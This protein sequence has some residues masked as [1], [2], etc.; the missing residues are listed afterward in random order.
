[1]NKLNPSREGWETGPLYVIINQDHRFPCQT[2]SGGSHPMFNLYS[3]R[4]T[5]ISAPWAWKQCEHGKDRW[6]GGLHFLHFTFHIKGKPR[7][8]YVAITWGRQQEPS[9]P[10]PRFWCR[11]FDMHSFMAS[12]WTSPEDLTASQLYGEVAALPPGQIQRR[13]DNQRQRLATPDFR[14]VVIQQ[15]GGRK[16]LFPDNF[17]LGYEM[18]HLLNALE[19]DIYVINFTATISRTQGLGRTLFELTVDVQAVEKRLQSKRSPPATW[20]VLMSV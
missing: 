17:K 1:M 20:H 8:V 14:D 6:I 15:P 4:T 16:R 3:A 11:I 12:A 18:D 5:Q 19:A 10:T 13:I 7:R 2:D 9:S